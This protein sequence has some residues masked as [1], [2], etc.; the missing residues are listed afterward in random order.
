MVSRRQLLAIGVGGLAA[1]TLSARAAAQTPRRGGTLSL[2]MWDP[3]HFD[4][5]LARREVLNQIERHLARQQYYVAA[6]SGT[7]VAVWDAALKN[8]GPN[9]GFDYGGRLMV[10]WLD[11]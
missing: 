3:P 6:P 10:S 5:I 9:I 1:A 7:Y 8:Y 4:H 2:R 11:R